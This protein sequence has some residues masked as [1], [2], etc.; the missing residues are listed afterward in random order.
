MYSLRGKI[1]P[2]EQNPLAFPLCSYFQRP[3][4]IQQHDRQLTDACNNN[5]DCETRLMNGQVRQAPGI[6]FFSLSLKICAWFCGCIRL[7]SATVARLGNARQFI[8]PSVRPS[9]PSTRLLRGGARS[10]A[11]WL[12]YASSIRPPPIPAPRWGASGGWGLGGARGLPE[13]PASVASARL[14]ASPRCDAVCVHSLI[15]L[16]ISYSTVAAARVRGYTTPRQAAPCDE[17]RPSLS[18][19]TIS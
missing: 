5:C 1:A 18:L 2:G 15:G 16:L 3:I 9:G 11:R 14:Q 12:L 7:N 10:M 6:F 8:H 4:L 13:T 19:C 17:R